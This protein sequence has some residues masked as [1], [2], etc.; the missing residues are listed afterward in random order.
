MVIIINI[1]IESIVHNNVY[2]YI[3]FIN[4]LYIIKDI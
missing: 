4:I 2:F 1:T 3:K